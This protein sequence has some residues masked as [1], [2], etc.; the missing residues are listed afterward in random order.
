MKSP[1]ALLL[2]GAFVITSATPI[3]SEPV[4]GRPCEGCE[5]VFE[6]LPSRFSS[7][8]RI[9]RA[10]QPGEA[11][12]ITGTVR[13]PDGTPAAGIVV[14]AYHTDARGVYP[15]GDTR[16]GALRGWVRTD[17]AGQYRFDTIRPGS[18]PNR[19]VPQHVHMHLIEPGK[20]T[21]YIDDIR[22]EDDPLL[23]EPER[24]R[25]RPRGGSGLVKPER[26][27]NGVWH[28]RRDI[29]LRLNVPE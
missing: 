16:H 24:E 14:Y 9:A 17:E 25:P 27:A 8:A 7:S 11:L 28:V 3:G 23:D 18:Y 5:L 29:T 1:V 21:Y 10:S 13:D 4:I 26:D 15:R 12:V 2:V 19:R 22:F 20:A 6:G